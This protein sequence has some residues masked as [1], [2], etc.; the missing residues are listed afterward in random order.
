MLS[1]LKGN[2]IKYDLFL[3]FA[4]NGEMSPSKNICVLLEKSIQR[5]LIETAA[6]KFQQKNKYTKL[7]EHLY[8][9]FRNYN[10]IK[11]DSIKDTYIFDWKSG[12]RFISYFYLKEL[13]R[14]A[15]IKL[16]DISKSAR[17]VRLLKNRNKFA[18]SIKPGD[19]F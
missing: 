16:S 5:K 6:S 14:Q 10:E 18:Y 1:C 9:S 8:K 3:F 12:K 17:K 2:N 11:L 13:A 15:N 4:T 7:A 19:V